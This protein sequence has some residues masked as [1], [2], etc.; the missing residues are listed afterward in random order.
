VPI[1]EA[2]NQRSERRSDVRWTAKLAQVGSRKEETKQTSNTK[3][4]TPNTCNVRTVLMLCVL[5]FCVLWCCVLMGDGSLLSMQRVLA[6]LVTLFCQSHWHRSRYL[7]ARKEIFGTHPVSSPLQIVTGYFMRFRSSVRSFNRP[8]GCVAARMWCSDCNRRTAMRG[9][10]SFS[11]PPDPCSTPAVTRNVCRTHV[12]VCVLQ[13]PLHRVPCNRK[14]MDAGTFGG[15]ESRG[16]SD[17]RGVQLLFGELVSLCGYTGAVHAVWVSSHSDVRCT[18]QIQGGIR[19]D[20]L[21]CRRRARLGVLQR[22]MTTKSWW[23]LTILN[24]LY[25]CFM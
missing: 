25:H 21:P 8:Y 19:Q 3:K 24:P 10:R 23:R 1:A 2:C 5:W 16:T 4:S 6:G 22:I 12:R 9:S 7:E 14:T 17:R 11:L 13:V 18:T 15:E 20:R